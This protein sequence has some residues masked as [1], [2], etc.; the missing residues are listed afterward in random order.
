[1]FEQT[2][3]V[4]V[5]DS[6]S[7]HKVADALREAPVIAIDTES[8]SSYAYQEKVCLIQISDAQQDYIVDPL[9]V[10]DLSPLKDVFANPDT[11]KV[12]HGADYDIVSL[13]R[14]HDL[15]IS[16]LF[17]TL[18]AAQ[19]LAMPRIGLADLVLRFF[20]IEL[21]KQY[22][23]HNW[24]LRPLHPEHIEY[25]RGDTH[26]LLALHELLVA[27]LEKAGRMAHQREECVL[28]EAREWTRQKDPETAWLD[29]K[30]RKQLDD[31]GLRVLRSLYAYRDEQARNADKPPYKIVPDPILIQLASNRPQTESEIHASMPRRSTMRRRHG[32]GLLAAVQRGM[33][34]DNPLPSPNANRK[35]AAGPKPPLTGR[36]AERVFLKLKD[37][38]KSFLARNKDRTPFMVASNATLLAIAQHQPAS[39]DDLAAVPNV[40][41]WQVNDFGPELL[42]A[43]KA[44]RQ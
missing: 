17:D 6:A 22:Q 24:G 3:L 37:W 18:F 36:Q 19:F 31:D 20:G 33:S 16:G 10:T 39:V 29:V 2:P 1:M 34:D 35:E 5:E 30:N 41:K 42:K 27:R 44:T 43:L 21:D 14:D 40:R 15:T 8:D 38:R 7:L 25:A 26:F 9:K 23:R 12:L 32:D 4:M 13:K 11:V 28:V